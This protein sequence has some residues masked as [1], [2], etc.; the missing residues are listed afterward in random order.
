MKYIAHRGYHNKNRKE[1]TLIAFKRA[2]N[3]DYFSGFELD[4]RQSKDK[5]IVVIHDAYIDR[6][7]NSSGL[8]K[9]KTAKELKKIGVPTLQ[10]VLKLTTDKIILIEI[11]EADLNI[12][13]LLK[14]IKKY[15]NRRIYIDSFNKSVI[16]KLDLKPRK[17]KLGT[18]N[19]ML[20]NVTNYPY[21]FIGIYK[22]ALTKDLYYKA[23]KLH[24]EVFVW[25]LLDIPNFD[26][27]L[28]KEENLYLIV[29]KKI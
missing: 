8:V 18:L 25:G 28:K 9:N 16:K 26:N 2:I 15:P 1:N 12:K 22:K 10:E 23:Q 7:S 19:F 4:I 6:I 20:P 5:K 13:N 14:I 24:K 11:K 21:D 27:S 29:N 17:Y 3:D